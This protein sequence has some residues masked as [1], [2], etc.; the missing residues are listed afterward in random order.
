MTQSEREKEIQGNNKRI[1][2]NTILLYLRLFLVMAI[3]LYTVRVVFRVL[4]ESDYGVYNVVAGIVVMFSFLS[5]TL[6][7]ASQRFFAFEL[8]RRN[9]VELKK[10]F[11]AF[12]LFYV[13]ASVIILLLSEIVGL[14]FLYNK[15]TIDSSR[16]NAASW[17][18]QCSVLSFLFTILSSPYQA[19]IIARE[20]MGVYAYVGIIEVILKLILVAS[21]E[22]LPG[23]KLI[24][25][26]VLMLLSSNI[27]F[28][29]YFIYSKRKFP[30][31]KFQFQWDSDLL[32]KITSY[33]GWNLMGGVA[34]VIRSQGIN[35]LLN[36][37]FS[38]VVNAARALAY[39][40]STMVAQFANNFYSAVRPQVT[41]YYAQGDMQQTTKLIFQSSKFSIALL[42]VIIIPVSF[43]AE[44]ILSL[45]IGNV[46]E[47]TVLFT[48]LV[49]VISI[50]D[51]VSNPLMTLVQA[52]GNVKLYQIVVS[53]ILVSNLPVSWLF[54]RLGYPP[55]T[56]MY[57]AIV[58]AL[59][60]LFAR[61]VIVNKLTKFPII[62]FASEVLAPM[63][64]SSLVSFIMVYTLMLVGNN[65]MHQI[66]LFFIAV[67]IV[68]IV[69]FLVAFKKSEKIW[70]LKTSRSYLFRITKR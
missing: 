59:V 17:V 28:L 6:S 4:G 55:E 62:S 65:I 61:L 12:V 49:L 2:Q 54:L 56:T 13:I 53:V 38:P 47:Y 39:N 21:L 44:Q 58:L 20:K 48:R 15:M 10:I 24:V 8:G 22:Y 33:S 11:S 18:F 69:T 70:I 35:M 57:V 1:L 7:S 64:V 43:F 45:W 29:L 5:N 34:N 51:A 68:S 25:Y 52:T 31:C 27:V 40:I 41:K 36:V 67:V 46:P 30:E 19:I 16:L 60:C 26:G 37:F 32:Y 14:W 9:F 66:L 3:S 42:L 50:V 63:I 23:D